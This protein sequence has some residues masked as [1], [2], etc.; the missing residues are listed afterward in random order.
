MT[1]CEMEKNEGKLV[2]ISDFCK[3]VKGR[4]RRELTNTN[5][6]LTR[7]VLI[8]ESSHFLDDTNDSL[9]IT[10]SDLIPNE[11]A[12]SNGV[13][14]EKISATVVD[15]SILDMF[16]L[17]NV[18]ATTNLPTDEYATIYTKD[19]Q[20][21]LE[22]Q[23]FN[24]DICMLTMAQAEE[25]L[26][27]R[28]QPQWIPAIIRVLSGTMSDDCIG[29]N[30]ALNADAQLLPSPNFRIYVPPT[31]AAVVGLHDYGCM[32]MP[33]KAY[34]SSVSEGTSA[35]LL[36]KKLTG[37]NA[38]STML[39][40]A[41]KAKIVELY[42][43][44]GDY[45][46]SME[47][48]EMQGDEMAI[49]RFREERKSK[50]IEMLQRYFLRMENNGNVCA[51]RLAT[52]GTIFAVINDCIIDDKDAEHPCGR[53]HNGRSFVR[54]YMILGL[55]TESGVL[56]QCTDTAQNQ[57]ECFCWISP[58]AELVLV[59]SEKD[60]LFSTSRMPRLSAVW[61][62][63]RSMQNDKKQWVRKSLASSWSHP[64]LVAILEAMMAIETMITNAKAKILPLSYHMLHL[65]GNENNHITFCLDAVADSGECP[66]P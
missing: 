46:P 25:E 63:Y 55:E 2:C 45:L 59:P 61:S 34:I 33:L 56:V 29:I 8:D 7:D 38:S 41:T 30:A 20:L 44:P 19:C 57:N 23:C 13:I 18:P 21:L 32:N 51:P 40:Y 6:S 17:E 4:R 12:M 35:H 31:L 42:S 27:N 36:P 58:K 9:N 28:R 43:P 60:K 62:F 1:D 39:P 66:Q 24:G 15:V 54:F 37:R 65:I 10:L 3:T 14:M 48:M 49:R 26:E 22:I 11:Q 5:T 53:F 50:Q 64:H 52:I 47:T 16:P